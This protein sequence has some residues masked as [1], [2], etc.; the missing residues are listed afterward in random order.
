MEFSYFIG[1]QY[2]CQSGWWYITWFELSTTCRLRGDAIKQIGL[3]IT[4]I[5]FQASVTWQETWDKFR[6]RRG[7]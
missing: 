3:S 1:R 6:L 2:S 4:I 7:F 5:G